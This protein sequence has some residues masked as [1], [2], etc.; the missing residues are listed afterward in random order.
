MCHPCYSAVG[1]PH[2]EM[3]QAWTGTDNQALCTGTAHCGPVPLQ[4]FNIL[5]HLT[6]VVMMRHNC[7]DGRQANH[8][9]PS[10]QYCP[11][12]CSAC[13]A[14]MHLSTQACL[15]MRLSLGSTQQTVC[16]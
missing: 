10:A 9:E 1:S 3:P 7:S 5:R 4:P 8:H 6:G 12:T 11:C 14:C 15:T 13:P 2:H 16:T